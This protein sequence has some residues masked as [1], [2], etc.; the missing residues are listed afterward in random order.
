MKTPCRRCTKCGV[1]RPSIQFETPETTRCDYCWRPEP[2]VS[3][4]PSVIQA[5]LECET[6]FIRK[7]DEEL[8]YCPACVARALKVP[9]RP[10]QEWRTGIQYPSGPVTPIASSASASSVVLDTCSACGK[11]YARAPG[12]APGNCGS[13]CGRKAPPPRKK[14][15][16][17][18]TKS[19]LRGL[20]IDR[21][22][23]E[24][25]QQASKSDFDFWRSSYTGIE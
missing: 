17:Q 16:R 12:D 5:C 11:G 2:T 1:T 8:E 21:E 20:E 10:R 9:R 7:A 22:I 23:R 19:E 4:P 14:K 25:R 6:Q 15:E 13:Q 18:L 24:R 3:S